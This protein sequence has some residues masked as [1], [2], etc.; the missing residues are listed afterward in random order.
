MPTTT[1]YGIGYTTRREYA[2]AAEDWVA[3]GDG[4]SRYT[5]THNLNTLAPQVSVFDAAG[6]LTACGAKAVTVHS[7][8]LTVLT[9]SVFAG[10][11]TVSR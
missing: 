10:R 2:F 4:T 5:V 7:L 11:L 9:A 6:E 1:V 8:Y 3:Q